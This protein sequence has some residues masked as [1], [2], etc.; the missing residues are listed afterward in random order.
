MAAFLELPEDM[1][2]G[3]LD[4]IIENIVQLTTSASL[5][6]QVWCTLK[7]EQFVAE[8]MSKHLKRVERCFWW[9]PICKQNPK[10]FQD[11]DVRV[12]YVGHSDL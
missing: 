6:V 9:K 7:Q 12:G 5:A 8:I 11:D 2:Q 10:K 1:A 3:Q 4:L